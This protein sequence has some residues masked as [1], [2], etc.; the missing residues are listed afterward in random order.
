[1]ENQRMQ[2][3]QGGLSQDEI[4]RIGQSVREYYAQLP[5][6]EEPPAPTEEEIDQFLERTLPIVSQI[7]AMFEIRPPEQDPN[8]C[9][10][11]YSRM[12]E[13]FDEMSRMMNYTFNVW[14]SFQN[15]RDVFH[16]IFSSR[17]R[18]GRHITQQEAVLIRDTLYQFQES[19]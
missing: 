4:N 10:G 6:P 16:P 18:Y 11:W 7:L 14:N 19:R 3:E 2:H 13:S 8:I 17:E 5:A 12:D 1:M 15:L 9:M